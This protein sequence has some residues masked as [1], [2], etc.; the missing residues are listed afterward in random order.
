MKQVIDPEIKYFEYNGK[1]YVNLAGYIFE[2]DE[3]NKPI[4]YCDEWRSGLK[5]YCPF[6][7]TI[8]KHGIGNGWRVPHC[9]NWDSPFWKLG[10]YCL[11]LKKELKEGEYEN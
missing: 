4:I 8:H 6:C 7:K 3:A 2:L 5:F 11:I 1:K 10:Q 9:T